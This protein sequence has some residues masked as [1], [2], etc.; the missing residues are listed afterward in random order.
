MA[1]FLS[2]GAGFPGLGPALNYLTQLLAGRVHFL[3]H[4]SRSVA[5]GGCF[6]ALVFCP[7]VI[8]MDNIQSAR[9]AKLQRRNIINNRNER[10]SRIRRLQNILQTLQ[11]NSNSHG[12]ML[13]TIPYLPKIFE[14]HRKHTQNIVSRSVVDDDESVVARLDLRDPVNHGAILDGGNAVALS[15]PHNAV[16]LYHLVSARLPLTTHSRPRLHLTSTTTLLC[17]LLHSHSRSRISVSS[18]KKM[19]VTCIFYFLSTDQYQIMSSTDA[20]IHMRA[21]QPVEFVGSVEPGEELA[22]PKDLDIVT[23]GYGSLPRLKAVGGNRATSSRGSYQDHEKD[24][25]I[26]TL[27]EQ[28]ATQAEQLTTQ[29]VQL[30]KDDQTIKARLTRKWEA[31]ISRQIIP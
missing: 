16:A 28:V 29:S 8:K 10:Q 17:R 15:C 13:T 2:P 7:E 18:N 9:L 20:M 21:S 6:G 5:V 27:K 19:S 1:Q 31:K 24:K 26:A 3:A 4:F 23:Q 30:E 14:V 12:N 25:V 22:K 11:P